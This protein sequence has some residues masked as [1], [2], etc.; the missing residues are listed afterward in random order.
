MGFRRRAVPQWQQQPELRSGV[1]LPGTEIRRDRRQCAGW[2]RYTLQ[3][4]AC[5]TVFR[6]SGCDIVQGGHKLQAANRLIAAIPIIVSNY[7]E[8]F[9]EFSICPQLQEGPTAEW[10]KTRAGRS[11]TLA[12]T[13]EFR[14]TCQCSGS[15]HRP[16]QHSFT[17]KELISAHC[18]TI[19]PSRFPRRKHI[20]S[21]CL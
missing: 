8:I 19:F 12:D 5:D 2:R 3:S 13:R 18:N 15:A 14:E 4:P 10:R 9:V 21:C 17:K 11:R 1:A 7:A 20:A 6:A 16:W